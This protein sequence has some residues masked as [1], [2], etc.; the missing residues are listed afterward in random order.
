MIIQP[1]AI[2]FT[3]NLQPSP[4][5]STPL[6]GFRKE[7]EDSEAKAAEDWREGN[8]EKHVVF[9]WVNGKA[10]SSQIWGDE[11][12]AQCPWSWVI[13]DPDLMRPVTKVIKVQGDTSGWAKPPVEIKTKVLFWPGLAWRGHAKTE[14]LFWF[15]REDWLNLMCHPVHTVWLMILGLLTSHTYLAYLF[16]LHF[17][18]KTTSFALNYLV[19]IAFSTNH[20]KCHYCFENE[21]VNG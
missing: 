16:P 13:N 20:I 19:I 14:L 4:F 6:K 11:F 10:N 8:E 7:T 3:S 17:R 18:W 15:Q 5:H 12:S 9:L 1:L 21:V 2:K